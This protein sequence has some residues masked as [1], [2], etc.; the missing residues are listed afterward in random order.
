MNKFLFITDH[1]SEEYCVQIVREMVSLFGI[2]EDEAL[3]RLNQ[4]FADQVIVGD[5][6]PFYHEM[7]TYWAKSIYYEP[8]VYWWLS[9]QGLKSRPYP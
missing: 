2:T 4:A 8:G 6:L 5:D 1:D 9:E 7:P 3:G